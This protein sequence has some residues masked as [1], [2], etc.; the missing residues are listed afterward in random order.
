MHE[1]RLLGDP[2]D[3]PRTREQHVVEDEG[4]THMH[5]YVCVICWCQQPVRLG[6]FTSPEG[7]RDG[8]AAL[9]R[10]LITPPLYLPPLYLPP[11]YLP[12]LHQRNEARPP[13]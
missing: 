8:F 6:Y 4:S 1:R 3:P 10:R 11:L 7:L 9:R 5:M 2:G 12:P 13:H